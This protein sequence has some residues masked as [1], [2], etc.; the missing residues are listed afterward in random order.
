[1][2]GAHSSSQ[3]DYSHL[4]SCVS[5]AANRRFR[6]GSVP[7]LPTLQQKTTFGVPQKKTVVPDTLKPP[8]P[9]L[10][11]GSIISFFAFCLMRPGPGIRVALDNR[12]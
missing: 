12:C 3:Y 6:L 5:D 4:V 10:V 11:S 1:L 8:N 2:T 7:P 9:H